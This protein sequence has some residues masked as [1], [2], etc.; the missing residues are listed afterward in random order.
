MDTSLTAV[1]MEGCGMHEIRSRALATKGEMATIFL[2]ASS[3]DTGCQK[4]LLMAGWWMTPCVY[5]YIYI[6]THALSDTRG[7]QVAVP[8]TQPGQ[9]AALAAAPAWLG[10]CAGRLQGG[11]APT[12]ISTVALQRLWKHAG[13]HPRAPSLCGYD[14]LTCQCSLS[15]LCNALEGRPG[16]TAFRCTCINLIVVPKARYSHTTVFFAELMYSVKGSNT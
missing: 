5:M 11:Q 8:Q 9:P 16:R 4:L 7:G 2:H 3:G 10:A 12:G 13:L 14:V 6:H 1:K 15:F